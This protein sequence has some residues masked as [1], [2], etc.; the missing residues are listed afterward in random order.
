MSFLSPLLADVDAILSVLSLKKLVV[1][2]TKLKGGA[3][4][5]TPFPIPSRALL[6][7]FLPRHFLRQDSQHAVP[8][9]ANWLKS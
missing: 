3:L 5:T 4:R 6:P 2:P 7:P 9:P 8:D 1:L